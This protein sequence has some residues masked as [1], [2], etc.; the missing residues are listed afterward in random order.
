MSKI[1]DRPSHRNADAVAGGTSAA[2][3]FPVLSLYAIVATAFVP[4]LYTR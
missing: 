4:L 1:Q 3:R 2:L